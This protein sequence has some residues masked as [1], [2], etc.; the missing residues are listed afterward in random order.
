MSVM[1]DM[2]KKTR[3]RNQES[4]D[5]IFQKAED[6]FLKRYQ[7]HEIVWDIPQHILIV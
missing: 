3:K 6:N 1:T 2:S 5:N 7:K 4:N